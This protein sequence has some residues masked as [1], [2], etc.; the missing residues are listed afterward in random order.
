MRLAR[1]LGE[2]DFAA[3]RCLV[4]LFGADEDDDSVVAIAMRI[5]AFLRSGESEDGG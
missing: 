2:D 4:T 3:A 5:A 1:K